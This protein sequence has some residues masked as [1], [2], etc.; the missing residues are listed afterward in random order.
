MGSCCS[1]SFLRTTIWGDLRGEYI[2]SVFKTLLGVFITIN[3]HT[4]DQ[5]DGSCTCCSVSSTPVC[6][7]PTFGSVPLSGRHRDVGALKQALAEKDT[8]AMVCGDV[9]V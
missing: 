1:V 6:I 7:S 4:N 8:A 9:I 5:Q 2:N 3:G